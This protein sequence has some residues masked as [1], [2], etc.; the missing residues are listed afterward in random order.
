M[1]T[2]EIL[3]ICK[4]I[5]IYLFIYFLERDLCSTLAYKWVYFRLL[6]SHELI[7]DFKTCT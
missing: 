3:Y 7:H 6:Y 2:C 5:I 1:V 4:K